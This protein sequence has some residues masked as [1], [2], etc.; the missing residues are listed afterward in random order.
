MVFN[1]FPVLLIVN[2]CKRERLSE[3]KV[4][5]FTEFHLNVGK[6]FASVA[7]S[8]LK[9]LKK[10]IAQK[11]HREN[12]C[13]L[14]KFH[15]NCSSFIL[16]KFCHLRYMWPKTRKTIPQ[17]KIFSV[18]HYKTMYVKMRYFKKNLLKFSNVHIYS[19]LRPILKT[20]VPFY[21][22]EL[23]EFKNLFVVSLYSNVFCLK[24]ALVRAWLKK[25][26][27]YT[28]GIAVSY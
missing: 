14:S 11:I 1:Y 15:K 6:T 25:K 26:Y 13:V 7:S 23:G 27:T 8:V 22:L 28:D 12:F 4:S 2:Y 20:W 10:A 19:I 21:S 3:R 16:L 18:M 5:W 17:S 9:E 24:R